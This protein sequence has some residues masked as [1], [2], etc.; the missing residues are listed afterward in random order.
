V[1]KDSISLEVLLTYATWPYLA[2]R[3]HQRGRQNPL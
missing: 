1:N 2:S 3:C